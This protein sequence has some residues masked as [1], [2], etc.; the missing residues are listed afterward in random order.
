MCKPAQLI[1]GMGEVMEYNTDHLNELRHRLDRETARLAAATKPR[2]IEM[3]RV[4]VKQYEKEIAAEV[5]ILTTQAA[6]NH[7]K[8]RGV[9]IE[10]ELTDDELLAELNRNS[11]LITARK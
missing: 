4:W 11:W 10:I 5:A 6:R 9:T 3:R 7:I 2:E 8:T 1:T